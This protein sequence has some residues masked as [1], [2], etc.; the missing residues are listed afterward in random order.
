MNHFHTYCV[1]SFLFLFIQ[2]KVLFH[3]KKSRENSFKIMNDE[4]AEG[5]RELFV[6]YQANIGMRMTQLICLYQ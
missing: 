4:D 2:I 3:L 5:F 1:R 6:Q